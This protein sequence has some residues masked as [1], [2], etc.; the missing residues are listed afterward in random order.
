[1]W[2][3]SC[4]HDSYNLP[5]CSGVFPRQLPP[6]R[7]VIGQAG[8]AGFPPGVMPGNGAPQTFLKAWDEETERLR[9]REEG[10]LSAMSK[11]GV[12]L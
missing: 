7:L 6:S 3:T 2:Q 4:P 11:L 12:S 8:H 5:G 1:M 9:A 10:L